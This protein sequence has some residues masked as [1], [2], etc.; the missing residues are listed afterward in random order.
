MPSYLP[1]LHSLHTCIIKAFVCITANI[2][3]LI[4]EQSSLTPVVIENWLKASMKSYEEVYSSHTSLGTVLWFKIMILC[5]IW[6]SCRSPHVYNAHRT[7]ERTFKAICLY[8]CHSLEGSIFIPRTKGSGDI[9][10]SL[11]S[12][13]RLSV[14]TYVRLS[15]NI[16]V[17]AE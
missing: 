8:N 12:V 1:M 2:K 4:A 6:W 5:L 15:V 7:R 16:F 13:R 11:A 9:A 14:R 3:L 17:S 10:M